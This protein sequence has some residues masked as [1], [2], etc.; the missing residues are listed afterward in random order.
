MNKQNLGWLVAGAA[1]CLVLGLPLWPRQNADA[2]PGGKAVQWE[3]KVMED[4]QLVLPIAEATK[5]YNDKIGAGGW[6]YAG[7]QHNIGNTKFTVFKRPK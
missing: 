6:E 4:S 3:Y 1:L 5:R 2:Q 7:V